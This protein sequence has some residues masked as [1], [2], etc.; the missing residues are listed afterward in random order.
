MNVASWRAPFAFRRECNGLSA[1]GAHWP[2]PVMQVMYA[3]TYREFVR[4]RVKTRMRASIHGACKP[5]TLRHASVTATRTVARPGALHRP[6]QATEGVGVRLHRQGAR[7]WPGECLSSVRSWPL[8]SR[9]AS[10][11]PSSPAAISASNT[12]SNAIARFWSNDD[13]MALLKDDLC[14]SD[15][16]ITDTDHCG[17]FS[18]G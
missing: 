14:F 2:L 10:A 3:K 11:D 18:V 13:G 5:L 16:F 9:R 8:R 12:V 7:H 17:G 4:H 15:G 6:K 1:T